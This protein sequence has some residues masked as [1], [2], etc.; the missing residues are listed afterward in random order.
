MTLPKKRT[1]KSN[2]VTKLQKQLPLSFA[3]QCKRLHGFPSSWLA[4]DGGKLLGCIACNAHQRASDHGPHG[5]DGLGARPALGSFNVRLRTAHLSHLRK[6][7]V[8][9]SHMA[10]VRAF[11]RLD[12]VDDDAKEC[13]APPTDHF[14]KVWS[15][16]CSGLAPNAGVPGVGSRHKV[17]RM[18]KCLAEG[19]RMVDR[20]WMVKAKSIAIA[21]DERDSRLVVRY[22]VTTDTLECR[23]GVLG[24]A[25]HFGSG[26]AAMTAATGQVIKD[27][28]AAAVVTVNPANL[29]THILHT[30]HQLAVDSASDETLSGRMMQKGTNLDGERPLTPNL[31]LITRDKA[32]GSR[33]TCVPNDPWGDS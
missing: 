22:S 33:R 15:S 32:H 13:K 16:I 8:L 1:K 26:A 29:E 19:I 30:I 17:A 4:W 18:V 20:Q 11:I 21:R 3:G 5:P 6:H 12:D 31:Q 14:I 23:H 9:P 24:Q 10:A 27:F 28:A 25:R 2:R 7:A